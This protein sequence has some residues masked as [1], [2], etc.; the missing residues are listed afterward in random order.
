MS[1]T[2]L[3]EVF[4]RQLAS[5]ISN[6]RRQSSP[7]YFLD[8]K[9]RAFLMDNDILTTKFP[10]YLSFARKALMLYQ[11]YSGTT[12]SERI[13]QLINDFVGYGLTESLLKG[14]IEKILHRTPPTTP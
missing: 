9:I 2:R 5:M 6:W 10:F 11:K 8:A 13:D 3:G 4:S 1:N 14:V 12:L 7:F